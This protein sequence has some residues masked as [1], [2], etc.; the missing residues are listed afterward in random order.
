MAGEPVLRRGDEGDW[1]KF[2]QENL[3]AYG[4]YGAEGEGDPVDGVFGHGTEDAVRACQEQHGLTVDG[5]VGPR[6]WAAL[7]GG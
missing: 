5:V 6:T 4:H 3:A 2:L 1:V 7:T